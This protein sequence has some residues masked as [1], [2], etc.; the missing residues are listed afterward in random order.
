MAASTKVPSAP[1]GSAVA[2]SLGTCARW[3]GNVMKVLC[4][5]KRIFHGKKSANARL[6]DILCWLKLLRDEKLEAQGDALI[7][8]QCGNK[9]CCVMSQTVFAYNVPFTHSG[10]ACFVKGWSETTKTE[11][12]L[13]TTLSWFFM[14]LWSRRPLLHCSKKP[15]E[16][17]QQEESVSYL[18]LVSHYPDPLNGERNT[19]STG[20][21]GEGIG[22][23]P[24]LAGLDPGHWWAALGLQARGSFLLLWPV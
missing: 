22:L 8:M 5:L 23:L 19:R 10:L 16:E 13:G 4:A 7:H 15:E 14:A 21:E 1:T 6:D 2:W 11:C 17:Q 20:I 18:W 3:Q 24:R 12:L 9:Y